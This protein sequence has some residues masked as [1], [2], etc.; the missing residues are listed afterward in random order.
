MRRVRTHCVSRSVLR[1]N[2]QECSSAERS[3]KSNPTKVSSLRKKGR[4][5]K[6]R[7]SLW[8]RCLLPQT[9]QV[10]HT[11]MEIMKRYGAGLIP[12]R[13]QG[14]WRFSSFNIITS[15]STKHCLFRVRVAVNT[16]LAESHNESEV[17][18]TTPK[19]RVVRFVACSRRVSAFLPLGAGRQSTNDDVKKQALS[20]RWYWLDSVHTHGLA[21]GSC[22]ACSSCIRAAPYPGRP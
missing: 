21:R 5:N 8:H 1:H 10:I 4:L 17:S 11:N 14:L 15:R 6:Q 7:I 16:R 20:S 3:F 2:S 18:A 22:I 12:P 19:T 9:K 13:K